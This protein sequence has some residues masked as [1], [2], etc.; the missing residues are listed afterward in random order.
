MGRKRGIVREP[1]EK[2]GWQTWLGSAV[3]PWTPRHRHP[4]ARPCVPLWGW[5]GPGGGLR[6]LQQQQALVGLSYLLVCSSS[7]LTFVPFACRGSE[8][9]PWVGHPELPL[10]FLCLAAAPF[11]FHAP[12]VHSSLRAGNKMHSTLIEPALLCTSAHLLE[13]RRFPYME[14]GVP[15]DIGYYQ[16][17]APRLFSWGINTP[18]TPP[19]L[20][21]AAEVSCRAGGERSSCQLSAGSGV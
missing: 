13:A 2:H 8:E 20:C 5:E 10:R 4:G 12:I 11:A 18:K 7:C 21:L 3:H 6:A 15:T 16:W 14:N 19:E 1:W 9:E 17:V